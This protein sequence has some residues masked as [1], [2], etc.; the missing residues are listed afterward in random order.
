V[1]EDS[2]FGERGAYASLI[3][4]VTDKDMVFFVVAGPRDRDAHGYRG[5]L[6]SNF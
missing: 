4:C 1:I 6:V 3:R 2:I 5:A